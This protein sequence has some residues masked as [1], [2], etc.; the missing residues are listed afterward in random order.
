MTGLGMEIRTAVRAMAHRPLFTLACIVTLAAGFG[1]V[2]AIFTV[3]E[4]V[5]LR[6]LPYPDSERMIRM[7]SGLE[8]DPIRAAS[9]ASR[10]ICSL[11]AWSKRSIVTLRTRQGRGLS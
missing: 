4:S 3:V 1:S 10:S 11:R 5:M 7:D 6:S 9:G 8:N 2:T